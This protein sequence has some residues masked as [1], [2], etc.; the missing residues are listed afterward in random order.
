MR[1]VVVG[2]GPAGLATALGLHA[3]G[4]DVTVLERATEVGGRVRTLAR[5][6]RQVELG[7]AGILDDAPDTT[8]LLR[9]LGDHGPAIVPA[10][11]VVKRRYL[12]RDGVPRALPTT[13]PGFLFGGAL[14]VAARFGVLRELFAPR[15]DTRGESIAAFAR[16]RVGTALAESLVQPMVL[17]VFGGDYELLELESAFPRM[18]A[19]E[20]A[21]GSVLRGLRAEAR[22]REDRGEARA[23]LITFSGGMGSL[24]SA[25]A[26]VLGARVRTGVR[27][28][29][30]ER[31][32][33]GYRLLADAGAVD[34]DRVMLA[35]ESDV[36]ADLLA[37]IDARITELLR[38][39]PSVPIA[40]VTLAIARDRVGHALDGFGLLVPRRERMQTMGV[41]FMTSIFPSAGIAPSGE[42]LFRVMMGGANDP[43]IDAFEDA[44]ILDAAE[45]EVGALLAFRAPA[46]FRHLQRWP[47]AIP[48]YTLGHKE[49]ARELEE[50]L[51]STRI[52]LVGTAVHGVGVNDVLRDAARTVDRLAT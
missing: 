36:A 45:R 16:R 6:G 12:V 20:A 51:S 29:A 37:P 1:V 13:P 24:P 5:D 40:S 22:D 28:L 10:D 30:I 3:R 43:S 38:T 49:R 17:G 46:H 47:R 41:L 2:A 25:M 50:R 15:G 23:R 9:A 4:I 42:A 8:A 27:V 32:G 52:S 35:T 44:A 14:S 18:A 11:P 19:L 33:Q 21:H 48:Q 39:I 31:A 7:P 26:S 34:A